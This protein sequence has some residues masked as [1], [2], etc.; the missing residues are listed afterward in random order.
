MVNLK[1]TIF[2]FLLCLTSTLSFAQGLLVYPKDSAVFD[3]TE[4]QFEWNSKNGANDYHLQIADDPTFTNLIVNN[5]NLTS[6]SY[7]AQNLNPNSVYYWRV[8]P[9][10]FSWSSIYSFT[11][12]DFRTWP[13]LEFMLDPDNVVLDA[14]GK[15]EQWTD[16]SGNGHHFGQNTESN[17]PSIGMGEGVNQQK[18]INFEPNL[19]NNLSGGDL[20]NLSAGEIFAFTK[21]NNAVPLQNSYSGIWRFGSSADIEFYPYTSGHANLAFGR[22]LRTPI[23]DINDLFNLK[24]PHLLNISSQDLFKVNINNTNI[25]TSGTGIVSFPSSTNIGKS[26]GNY[27]FDGQFGQILLFNTVLSD[28]LRNLVY[29]QMQSKYAPPVNLGHNISYQYGFCKDT[30]LYAGKRFTSYLWSDGSTA[31]SLVVSEPGTYWVEV[32]DIFGFISRDTIEVVSG[33]NYPTTQLYCQND[34]IIWQTGLGQQYSYLWS[35]GSTADTLVINSPGSYHVTVTDTNG[36]VFKSDTLSFQ[37]DLFPTSATLG[38]D[39]NLCSGNTLSLSTGASEAVSYL[40]NTGSTDASIVIVNTGE[41]SVEVVNINGCVAKDTVQVNIIGS[42]PNI[43]FSVPETICLNAEATFQ[44][45]SIPTDGA[46]INDWEWVILSDTITNN[47]GTWQADSVGV[48]DIQYTIGTTSGCFSDTTFSITVRPLPIVSMQTQGVCQDD[49]I[50]FYAGQLTPTFI[51]TWEWNYGDVASGAENTSFLQNST[52]KFSMSGAYDITL[53]GTDIYGCADTITEVFFVQPKPIANFI[54]LDICAG[55]VVDFENTSTIEVGGTIATYQ[56]DFGDG[57]YSGQTSPNK[58]Y[59]THGD[60]MVS[61]VAIS[62]MGCSDTTSRMVKVHAL[63]QVDYVVEQACAKTATRLI[64]NSFVPNGSVALVDWSV[65]NAPPLTGFVVEKNFPIGGTYNLKQTVKSAF[66]CNNS[67]ETTFQIYNEIRADFVHL[68]TVFVANEPVQFHST[69]IG[70]NSYFWKF[71]DFATSTQTDTTIVFTENQIG[72]EIEISLTVSNNYDCV[73]SISLSNAVIGRDTDLALTQIF[74]SEDDGFTTIGVRMENNGS[75][76]IE[77]VEFAI[78]E[79]GKGTFKEIWSGFLAGGESIIHVLSSQHTTGIPEMQKE[80]HFFCVKGR[81]LNSLF[82]EE[83]LANNEVCLSKTDADFVLIRPFPNPIND[84][85][86]VRF[87]ANVK[88]ENDLVIYDALGQEV[89][90]YDSVS[91]EVG[92]TDIAIDT[93]SW[94]TGVY[95]VKFGMSEVNVVK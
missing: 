53:I 76:P 36:C 95:V 12:V 90:R 67:L 66:G 16:L 51:D 40:W 27:Y 17:R 24:S 80:H 19:N 48:F 43:A 7:L 39:L 13:E 77:N 26:N 35:D 23:L 22:S 47:I 64:D 58:P 92:I 55:N 11:I 45:M 88:T 2:S 75:T 78:S 72:E 89:Y 68:P 61:L 74:L 84:L 87:I 28:S 65:N 31:D 21:K 8:K 62:N 38:P 56:W 81:L 44:D 15:V 82:E 32:E 91:L 33:L 41:Y 57:N 52:H 10:N 59:V 63:P 34:S 18:V 49:E 25:L 9:N 71:G 4:I 20:S 69:S 60:Y 1:P 54:G 6:L 30:T 93:Q 29:G 37:E 79:A 42:A 46:T 94:R 83:N 14:N 73:D 3:V 86:T 5:S 85:M 70:A 50:Q